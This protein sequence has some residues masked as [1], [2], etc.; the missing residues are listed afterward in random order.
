MQVVCPVVAYTYTL[1]VLTF[2]QAVKGV[3]EQCCSHVLCVVS[4][5]R[6]LTGESR[7]CRGHAPNDTSLTCSVSYL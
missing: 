2:V 3:L 5:A 1:A 6:V 7:G 4:S